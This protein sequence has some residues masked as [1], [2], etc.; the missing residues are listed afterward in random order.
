MTRRS[1]SGGVGR[2]RTLPDPAPD[3]P[4]DTDRPSDDHLESLDRSPARDP[5]ETAGS[6]PNR[7]VALRYVSPSGAGPALAGALASAWAPAA[8]DGDLWTP[9]PWVPLEERRAAG[10]AARK[11]V[12]R[13]SQATL[14]LAPDRD[15]LM[16]LR[17]QEQDRLADLIPLRHARMAESPFAYYRGTPAV[18]AADLGRTPRTDIIVQAGGDSHCGNFG[19]FASPERRLVF[20]ANDFD[21]TLPAPWEWDVKRLTAS[22]VI[23]GRANG[24]DAR[25]NRTVAMETVRSYREWMTRYAGMHLLDVWYAHIG[26]SEIRAALDLAIARSSPSRRVAAH[27]RASLEAIFRRAKGRDQLKAAAALTRMVDGRRV[28]VDQPPVL[29][30]VELADGPR[31]LAQ[32]FEAYRATMTDN[33]REFLERY[34][35]ADWALKV[36]GVGSVGTRCFVVVLIGSD[37]DDPLVL[38]AKEATASVLEGHFDGSVYANHGQRV[39]AGQRVMQATPDIFLGWARGPGGR[40][41]YFR[42]LWDMKGSVDTS[43]LGLQ[44]LGFY[45]SLCAWSLA[46][47]HARSGDAAAI[48]SYLG[49]ADTFDGA[50]ADFSEAYA[51]VNAR[52]HRAFVEAITSGVV[53]ASVV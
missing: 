15:P 52:D 6:P 38:Q 44:G 40:D 18:M 27:G 43:S 47:A 16:I 33:R 29:R 23:A 22:I 10:R 9:R 50:I 42:Q 37:D 12:P 25:Q 41:Y 20:D 30:H 36:V 5:V 11:R 48:A 2:G 31:V 14:E 32:V 46:R 1:T 28:L 3:T 19:L 7:E 8:P 49:T 4:T 21:E 13:S 17:A 26:E 35:F 34:R 39:V 51:D 45:G 24:F 53:E